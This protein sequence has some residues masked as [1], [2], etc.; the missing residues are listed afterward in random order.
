MKYYDVIIGKV[1]KISTPFIDEAH[2]YAARKMT[3]NK[4]PFIITKHIKKEG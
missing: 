1:I 2:D 4:K 3:Q